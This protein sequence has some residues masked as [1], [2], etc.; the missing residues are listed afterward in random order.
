MVCQKNKSSPVRLEFMNPLK[1]VCKVVLII[2]DTGK[3]ILTLRNAGK[4][5]WLDGVQRKLFFIH[6]TML[7][8]N[9]LHLIEEIH[10]Q[11]WKCSFLLKRKLLSTVRK[12]AGTGM[13][14][15]ARRK[16]HLSPSLMPLTLHGINIPVFLPSK[17]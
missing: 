14:R 16:N 2:L 10:Y 5:H 15:K 13:S 12:M 7:K 6:L 9:F 11:I 17:K 8:I 4:T 3:W 1:I